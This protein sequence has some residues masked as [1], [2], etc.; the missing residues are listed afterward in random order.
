MRQASLTLAALA[1]GDAGPEAAALISP[2]AGGCVL[3]RP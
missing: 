2:R 1:D 3:D